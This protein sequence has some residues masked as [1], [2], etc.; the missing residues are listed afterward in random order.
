LIN[1]AFHI[2]KSVLKPDKELDDRYLEHDKLSSLAGGPD[3]KFSSSAGDMS[4]SDVIEA[5]NARQYRPRPSYQQLRGQHC[6]TYNLRQ[7]AHGLKA[8][9]KTISN[10]DDFYAE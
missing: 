4:M 5:R 10:Y 6:A 3:D 8:F 2:D 7:G 1:S 9:E